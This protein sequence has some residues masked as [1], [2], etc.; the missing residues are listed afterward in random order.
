M[1]KREPFLDFIKG[2]A[3]ILVVWGHSIQYWHGESYDFWHDLFFIMIYS[4]HMPLFSLVSGYVMSI[5]INRYRSTYFIRRKFKALV[6]P[7]LFWG[8]LLALLGTALKVINEKIEGQEIWLKLINDTIGNPY[9]FFIAA[10]F[11]LSSI[12]IIQCIKSSVLKWIIYTGVLSLFLVSPRVYHI[13]EI[14]FTFPCFI[15]GFYFGKFFF[16]KHSTKMDMLSLLL[17]VMMLSL[18][19]K[20]KYVYTTGV[21]LLQCT[22]SIRQLYIDVYR[23]SIGVVG[24]FLCVG[25]VR[26]IYDILDTRRFK[27]IICKVGT[28]SGDIYLLSTPVFIYSYYLFV[29][30]LRNINLM[31][32]NLNIM[33]MTFVDFICLM[34]GGSVIALILLLRPF[35]QKNELIKH[36]AFGKW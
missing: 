16:G 36:F 33:M 9:W 18:W 22:D 32:M 2:V 35:L 3:I 25:I 34:G 5:N 6:I 26:R 15:I 24:S 29:K 30:L 13:Q 12:A 31:S 7:T 4:F 20:E 21:S 14:A 23:L 19:T 27:E 10:F 28:S 11:S 17:Y 8:I 1:E